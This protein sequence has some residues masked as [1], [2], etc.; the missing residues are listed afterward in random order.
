LLSGRKYFGLAAGLSMMPEAEEREKLKKK[1]KELK[2]Y[3]SR[4]DAIM[5]N[6]S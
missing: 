3:L 1:K 5:A 6:I 4:I 2:S